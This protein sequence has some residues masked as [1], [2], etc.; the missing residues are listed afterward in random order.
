MS[1]I[2]ILIVVLVSILEI[3][4]SNV[5][6][7]R[8]TL[9]WSPSLH[10]E[11]GITMLPEGNSY[12]PKYK[13]TPKKFIRTIN[14]TN[15]NYYHRRKN[16]F[17]LDPHEYKKSRFHKKSNYL[18]NLKK[19][20]PIENW[21]YQMGDTRNSNDVY[22]P[23]SYLTPPKIG[24]DNHQYYEKNKKL[25]KDRSEES[26]FNRTTTDKPKNHR[27]GNENLMGQD[28]DNDRPVYIRDHA[29]EQQVDATHD[30]ET[31]ENNVRNDEKSNDSSQGSKDRIE[32]HIHG[33]A[34]PETYMFGFD[35]GDGDNRQYRMEERHG[36]GTITGHYGYIDARGKLRKV[37]YK[38]SPTHG[39]EEKH[40]ET[41]GSS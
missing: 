13:K 16:Y 38:A 2:K 12:L 37:R 21:N 19:K 34:G 4:S 20:Y 39:Y 41:Q 24:S 18:K 8:Q 7:S 10:H 40:H 33:H 31:N 29:P 23:S 3:D 25:S 28:D 14:P 27:Y 1:T 26:T 32:F 22:L 5:P 35:T 15:D 17:W 11:A 6:L 30:E 9:L 36:D